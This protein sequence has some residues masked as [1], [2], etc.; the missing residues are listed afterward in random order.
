MNWRL[1]TCVFFAALCSASLW[2]APPP[3]PTIAALYR[4]GL[5]GDPQ[6]VQ[7]CIAALEQRLSASPN[8][9]LARVYLGSAYTLRSRDLGFGKAKLGAL[10][11]G[12]AL[13]DAAAAAAPNDAHVALTRAVTTEALPFFLGRRQAAREQL[14]ALVAMIEKDPAR[15]PPDD[16]Q[17]LY[18][19]AGEAAARA[20]DKRR[21]RELWERGLTIGG[22]ARLDAEIRAALRR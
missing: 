9:Q 12:I 7:D 16:R 19:N 11:K 3:D 21:A 14:F 20:G 2:A 1:F 13:M 18:L 5:A 10:R 17:L 4:R 22:D 8:D 15:L 6:A